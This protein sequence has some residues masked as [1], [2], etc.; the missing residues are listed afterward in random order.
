MIDP[1][2]KLKIKNLSEQDMYSLGYVKLSKFLNMTANFYTLIQSWSE[3]IV[4]EAN[5]SKN[6]NVIV[7]AKKSLSSLRLKIAEWMK[8]DHAK[9]S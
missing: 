8:N 6:P 7:F 4:Q 9:F 2:L 5:D 1:E 3:S